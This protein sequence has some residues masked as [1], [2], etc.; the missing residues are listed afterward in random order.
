MP[1]IKQQ[2]LSDVITE[3]LEALILDGSFVAGQKLPAE[4]MLAEQFNVS[5]PSLREAIQN[6]QAKGL[7][8]RKQGGGTFVNAKLN[9]NMTDPLL[10]LVANRP[11][12][13][14]DLLEFRHA[15]EGMAAYYAALR[16]Q[17]EDYQN[18]QRA[19]LALDALPLSS[20]KAQEA[21]LLGDFYLMMAKASHN[22]VL[23]HVMRSMKTM[24]TDNIQRNLEMLKVMPD[25]VTEIKQHRN[26]I[27]QAI[28]GQ[29]PENAREASN[30]L[31]AFIEETLLK[32]NQRD[33]RVQRVMRRLDV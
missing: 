9:S 1:G 18:L 20:T 12:T 13:Q 28:I 5:R 7:V 33:T 24:L 19:W 31:L 22:M 26:T 11:E 15:L 17:P 25:A 29:D 10:E 3:R 2:K 14:F 21:E 30:T 6:L 27:V 32:I 8:E 16:G 23:Q 4:R